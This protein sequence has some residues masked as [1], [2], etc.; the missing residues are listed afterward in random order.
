VSSSWC[1]NGGN[2]AIFA[3]SESCY[4]TMW[5]RGEGCK[6]LFKGL[7]ML[8]FQ[9]RLLNRVFNETSFDS[10][11]PKLEPKLVSTPSETRSLFQLFCFNI[12][13]TSFGVSN[14]PKQKKTNRNK[15]NKRKPEKIF[16]I[17]T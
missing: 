14:E 15:P 17:Q 6:Q 12:K 7:L 3:D 8:T 10:K 9:K 13:T 2:G 1:E 11:Q 4:T 5:A 16:K